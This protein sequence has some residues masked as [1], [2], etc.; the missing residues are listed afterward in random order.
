MEPKLGLFGT[1]AAHLV[2]ITLGFASWFA[3]CALVNWLL[4]FFGAPMM[5]FKQLAAAAGILCCVNFY[6]FLGRKAQS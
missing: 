1:V 5:T 6:R 3:A 4:T 2:G